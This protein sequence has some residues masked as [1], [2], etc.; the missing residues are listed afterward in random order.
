MASSDASTDN[1]DGERCDIF[2][3]TTWRPEPETGCRFLAVGAETIL[4]VTDEVVGNFTDWHGGFLIWGGYFDYGIWGKNLAGQIDITQSMFQVVF[5][6]EPQ[7]CQIMAVKRG[8]L[9]GDSGSQL[10]NLPSPYLTENRGLCNI[11]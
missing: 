6:S 11:A 3:V 4:A 8:I 7:A 5:F 10:K 1:T 2:C 9:P